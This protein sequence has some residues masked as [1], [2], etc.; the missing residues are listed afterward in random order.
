MR[1]G[2]REEGLDLVSEADYRTQ[3]H[4]IGVDFLPIRVGATMGDSGDIFQ[5]GVLWAIDVYRGRKRS[6]KRLLP[7]GILGVLEVIRQ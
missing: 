3:H 1:P 6:N 5:H 4:R 2:I 7:Q